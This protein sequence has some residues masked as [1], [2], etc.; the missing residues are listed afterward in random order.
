VLLTERGVLAALPEHTARTVVV[1]D[2]TTAAAVAALP[3][4]ALDV[5]LSP[6]SAAYVIYTS[7]STGR[8]KG[9]PNTHRGLL[10]RLD[11]MQ[12]RFG[13]GPGDA[14]LQKTPAGFDVSVWEFFWPLMVGAR[15]AVAR[16]EG[17]KDT[18]YLARLIESQQVTV[19]HF[20][21]SMLQVFLQEPEAAKC[22]GVRKVMC[23]GEALSYD[24]QE[25][26]FAASDAE[27]HNLYGPTEAS[28]DV[29]YWAC[30]RGGL[31]N[32]VPIGR[33]IANIETYIL[34]SEGQPVPVGVAGELLLGGVGLARG[35][36]S[37]PGLTAERFIPNPFSKEPG[38]RLYRTGDLARFLPGG[39]IEYLGRIDHQVKIRGFRIELGEIEAAL[40]RHEGVQ[41]SVV[42][43]APEAGG[44]QRLVAYVVAAAG[45]E[46]KPAE[47][48][49]HLLQT[50]PEYMAPQS[51][52]FLDALPLSSNGKIDRKALPSPEQGR[53]D[54]AAPFVAPRTPLEAEVAAM[55]CELLGVEEVGI[56][57]SF[58][59]LGGHSLLLTQLA[60]RLR[61]AFGVDLPLRVLFNAP[62][63]VEMTVAISTG[64]LELED[65]SGIAEM[66]QELKHLSP[67]EVRSMLE[68]SEG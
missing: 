50:L 31:R 51:F 19:L 20:V 37:R 43:A 24:L 13:I 34:S 60:S 35:Y 6:A 26:F 53:A 21:P 57:D 44:G 28:V 56:H 40:V 18:A 27:L 55:W 8:P 58:F 66:L 47:L 29:T 33:P 48:R 17:H 39:E 42:V 2:G 7:G 23:S 4:T 59:E 41:E 63:V 65:T 36:L 64:Q 52:V 3:P 14:V 67:D 5:A 38:A 11:W 15:L 68:T 16:P 1:D 46:P 62:T 10:N 30:E 9:V 61:N 32:V 54:D 49:G 12:R 25:R 45:H 22:R